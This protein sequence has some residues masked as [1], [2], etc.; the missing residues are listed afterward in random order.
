[1][2]Q[3]AS[4]LAVPTVL[5]AYGSYSQRRGAYMRDKI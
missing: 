5:L 1:M 4:M 2:T 3:I